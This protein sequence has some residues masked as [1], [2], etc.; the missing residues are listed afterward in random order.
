[1]EGAV[2][3][4]QAAAEQVGVVYVGRKSIAV[5]L[6]RVITALAEAQ[7]VLIIARGNFVRKAVS[8]A[9]RAIKALGCDY[10]VRIDED[11]LTTDEQRRLIPRVEI[12]LIKERDAH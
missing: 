4:E 1:M 12:R 3:S 11:V 5:Y 7:E 2:V 10:H 8:V 6:A 9:A